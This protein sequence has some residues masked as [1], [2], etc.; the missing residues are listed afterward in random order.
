M[1]DIDN[2]IDFRI[3]Y[4]KI[5][6]NTDNN[7]TIFTQTILVLETTDEIQARQAISDAVECL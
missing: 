7:Q 1:V 5:N 3:I 2:T 4:S 6:G